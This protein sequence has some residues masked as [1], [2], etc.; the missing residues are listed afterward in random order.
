LNVFVHFANFSMAIYCNFTETRILVNISTLFAVFQRLC[1]PCSPGCCVA[2]FS[3]W[4]SDPRL[5]RPRCG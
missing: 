4:L 5:I 2:S 3:S 1:L